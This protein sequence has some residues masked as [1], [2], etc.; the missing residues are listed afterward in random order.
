VTADDLDQAYAR[1]SQAITR[2][3]SDRRELFLARLVLLLI[4][5]SADA[6][7]VMAD[8]S[9]AEAEAGVAAGAP[10]GRALGAS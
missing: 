4:S 2:V 8:I 1:L 7:S 6:S 9:D 10:N 3:P 5:S